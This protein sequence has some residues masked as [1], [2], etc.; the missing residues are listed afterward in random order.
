ME[1]LFVIANWKSN[2]PTL[3]EARHIFNSVKK[4]LKNKKNIEVVIC[5]PFVYLSI[6]K[7]QLLNVK[8]GAQ[9]CFWEEKGAYTGEI[10][11]LMLKNMGAEYVILG[12]SERRKYQRETDEM[13]SK[14]IKAA[15]KAGLKVILC[16]DNISQ[17]KKDLKSLVKKE[18]ANLIIAYEPLFAV[19]TG[20][21]CSV[22]EAKKMKKNIKKFLG[23]NFFILYGGSV[24]SQNARSYIKEAGFSGLL[25]GGASLNPKEFIDILATLQ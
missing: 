21:P 2:P 1:K 14:K 4:G 25:V 19:G 3:Q 20:N 8:L 13:I 6:V 17:I 22:E 10:P 11:A 16:V 23:E 5:P 7:S 12:H 15:L 18:L 24:S 9:D